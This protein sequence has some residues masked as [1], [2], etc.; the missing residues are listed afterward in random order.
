MAIFGPK[1]TVSA[2]KKHQKSLKRGSKTTIFDPL[3]SCFMYAKIQIFKCLPSL[4]E[5]HLRVNFWGLMFHV[6]ALHKT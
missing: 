2:L 6:C 4:F 5:R 3:G 1:V